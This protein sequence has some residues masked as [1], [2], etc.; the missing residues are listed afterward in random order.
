MKISLT[1][2]LILLCLPAALFAQAP[3]TLWTSVF[4]SSFHERA[5]SVIQTDDGGFMVA[6]FRVLV[7]GGPAAIWLLK[8]DASGDTV[9]TKT[10]DFGESDQAFCIRPTDDGGYIVTGT[11]RS[12]GDPYDEDIFLMKTDTN[13]DSSW[14]KVFGGDEYDDAWETQQTDDGGYIIVGKTESFGANYQCTY[15]I[16]TDANGDTTWTKTFGESGQGYMTGK[17]VQQTVDGGYILVGGTQFLGSNYDQ[18]YLVKTDQNGNAEW[19]R[20][21]GEVTT[22]QEEGECVRQT[23]DGGYIIVGRKR[24]N[25]GDSDVWLIK[26]DETGN[27]DWGQTYGG[28]GNDWGYCVRQTTEGGY[29]VC[30]EGYFDSPGRTSCFIIKTDGVGDT[31]WTMDVGGTAEDIMF[32][33]IET[34]GEGYIAAGVTNSYAY[35]YE[36]LYLIRLGGSATGIRQSTEILPVNTALYSA[37]PN[38][39]NPTTTIS[40]VLPAA[41]RLNLSVYDLS[42]RLVTQ[43]VDGFR[44]SGGHQATFDGSPLTSGIYIYRLQTGDFT[45]SGKMVLLK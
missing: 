13:G 21:F 7:Y 43:L 25:F 11:T 40:Y 26:V 14:F 12:W 33:I 34:S 23:A 4:G 36:D 24:E 8:I 35:G 31:L 2:S 39:F 20:D 42:G 10:Y 27:I 9:Y 1:I 28:D 6:G 5:Y 15:L 37:Y 19:V 22:D 44:D 3:D 30:G 41:G 45:A 29:I 17:S 32:E 18:V 16:K 38:P